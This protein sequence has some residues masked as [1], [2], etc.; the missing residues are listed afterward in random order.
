MITL[1]QDY[2]NWKNARA[3]LKKSESYL[4]DYRKSVTKYVPYEVI[5]SMLDAWH[6]F[7]NLLPTDRTQPD[8]AQKYVEIYEQNKKNVRAPYC[9]FMLSLTDPNTGIVYNDNK[10]QRCPNNRTDGHIEEFACQD[11]PGII[12][13]VQY[14]SFAQDVI[15]AKQEEHCAKQKLMSHFGIKR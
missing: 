11:C 15:K 8:Y 4:N 14:Q 7:K 13:L 2:K 6:E 3:T 12:E 5:L 1:I 10:L 9:F